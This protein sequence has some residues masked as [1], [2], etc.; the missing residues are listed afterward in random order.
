MILYV[1]SVFNYSCVCYHVHP[2]S[3]IFSLNC[4]T[5]SVVNQSICFTVVFQTESKLQI[6]IPSGWKSGFQPVL[7]DFCDLLP[8]S[9]PCFDP[10]KFSFIFCFFCN[11]QVLCISHQIYQSQSKWTLHFRA[12]NKQYLKEEVDWTSIYVPTWRTLDWS[13]R[14]SLIFSSIMTF[15]IQKY[16][17]FHSKPNHTTPTF[18]NYWELLGKFSEGDNNSLRIAIWISSITIFLIIKAK[19]IAIDKSNLFRILLLF[20]PN[21]NLACNFRI[22]SHD[23]KISGN[24]FTLLTTYC[25]SEYLKSNYLVTDIGQWR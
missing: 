4:G 3:S 6:W 9:K 2:F 12:N 13:G 23:T 21:F 14:L 7:Q 24:R 11:L 10:G 15:S 5:Y 25:N 18:R 22:L 17:N 8:P 1:S 20:V 16:R 19:I